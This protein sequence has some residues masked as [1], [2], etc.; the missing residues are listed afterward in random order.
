MT[1]QASPNE[2]S[3]CGTTEQKYHMAFSWS[4]TRMEQTHKVRSHSDAVPGA[5]LTAL[6]S[7]PCGRQWLRLHI[8]FSLICP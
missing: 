5:S 4:E 8:I 2:N 3:S 7:C 1:R 6:H